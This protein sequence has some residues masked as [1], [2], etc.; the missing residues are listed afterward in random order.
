MYVSELYNSSNEDTLPIAL[1]RR[2]RRLHFWLGSVALLYIMFVSM[3]GCAI[4]FE[5]ELYHLLS[6]DPPFTLAGGVLPDKGALKFIVAPQYPRDA[7]I[8]IWDRRLSAGMAAEIWLKRTNGIERRIVHPETGQD[9]GEVSPPVLRLL[10]TMRRL[11]ISMMGG[12]YGRAINVGGALILLTL[13]VTGFAA[14]RRQPLSR[15]SP[16]IAGCHRFAGRWMCIFAAVWAITGACLAIPAGFTHLLGSAAE[17][18]LEWLYL[19]HT[20]AIGGIVTR[21]V[22]AACA[23]CLS[24]LAV[25][26]FKMLCNR[27]RRTTVRPRPIGSGAAGRDIVEMST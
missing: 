17:P 10:E 4:I 21:S 23:L 20:G 24:F 9:L 5:H 7:I 2:V 16:T 27:A 13:S 12:T 26:G 6:P 11:H 1:R 14:R 19:V 22:W 15:P 25:T 8:G 3:S 18:V